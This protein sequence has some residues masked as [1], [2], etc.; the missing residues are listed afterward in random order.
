VVKA[1]VLDVDQTRSASRWA[2]SS[3]A[4]RL[5]KRV[6]GELRKGATVTCEVTEVQENGLEVKVDHRG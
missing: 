2:S 1:I 6:S 3:L 4:A 5:L